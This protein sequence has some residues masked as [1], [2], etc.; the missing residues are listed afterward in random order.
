MIDS[1]CH[2]NF[3]SLQSNIKQVI[4]NAKDNNI[5]S[6]LSI[7]TIPEDFLNHYNLIKNFQSIFIS[8]GFGNYLKI[9]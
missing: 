2:L 5:T 8:Y 7:N 6:I 1:H 3:D 4:K 9:I